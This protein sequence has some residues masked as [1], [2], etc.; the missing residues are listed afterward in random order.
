MDSQLANIALSSFPYIR[1][2]R[3]FIVTLLILPYFL[4]SRLRGVESHIFI[5]LVSTT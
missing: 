4:N 1:P 2:D 3:H 5:L